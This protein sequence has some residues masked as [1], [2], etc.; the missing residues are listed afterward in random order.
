MDVLDYDGSASNMGKAALVDLNSGLATAPV[1]FAVE[2]FPNE[3]QPMIDRTFK[4]DDDVDEAVHFVR[5]TDGIQRTKD[6]AK[7]HVEFAIDSILKS[8]QPSVYRDALV[9]LAYKVTDRTR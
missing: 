5:Q 8:L 4:N 7:V 3:I 2:K 9:H 6:L 1:L